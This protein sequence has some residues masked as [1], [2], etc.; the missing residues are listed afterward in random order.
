MTNN[1]TPENALT[2][3]KR[4]SRRR[5]IV[6]R[7]ALAAATILLA[8]ACASPEEKVA[9][10]T[11]SGEGFLEEG[12]WGKANVQFRNALKIDETHVPALEGMVVVAERKNNARSMFGLLQRIVR[13]DPTNV[14]AKTKI[15]KMYL[16]AGDSTEAL[17]IIDEALELAP[18][19]AEAIAAKSAILYKLEDVAQA[20]ELARKA[21]SIN[22]ALQEAVTVIAADLVKQG[23]I[24]GALKEID[25]ALAVDKSSTV[26]HLLRIEL[27]SKE[28]R[29]KDVDSAHRA[30]IEEYPDQAG[31]RQA[32]AQ[33][34]VNWGRLDEARDQL[35]TLTTLQPNRTSGYVDVVRVDYQLGGEE[36]ADATFQEFIKTRTD[37]VDLRFAYAA[38]LR[39]VGRVDESKPIYRALASLKDD[40]PTVLKAK[41]EIAALA[42]IDEDRETAEK[43]INEILELDNRNSEALI[44]K[45]TLR[46]LDGDTDGAIGDLR[47]VLADA[48]EIERAK[49]LIAAA[50]EKKGEIEAAEAQYAE[51]LSDTDSKASVAKAFSQFLLRHNKV[52]RAERVLTQAV[53]VNNQDQ[54]NLKLLAAIRLQKQDWRG[55]EE[56]AELLK[57]AESEDAAATRI[58]GVAYAGLEDFTGAIDVLGAEN[59]KTPLSSRPLSTLITAYMES[60]RAEEAETLLRANIDRGGDTYDA[61]VLLA[62]VLLAGNRNPEAKEALRDAIDATPGRFEAYEILYRV[63]RLEGRQSDASTLLDQ[64][65]SNAPENDGLRVLK[66]DL[67]LTNGQ[68]DEAL[69]LYE[70]VLTRRPNDI[71]VSNNYAA[72]L[73]DKTEDP[74]ALARAAQ[75]AKVLANSSNPSF[76]DTYGWATFRA[77]Q[78]AVGIAALEK[79]VAGA[80]D[81][82][83]AHFHLGVALHQTGSKDRARAHLTRVVDADGEGATPRAQRA[84]ELLDE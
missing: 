15:A 25:T 46:I 17:S 60:G 67:L 76:L 59:E 5:S 47:L 65:I 69:A 19:D 7:G 21:L 40:E 51:A 37:D 44:K 32:Y 81:L 62:R 39:Q 71:I 33:R 6:F 64:A 2:R 36:R 11:E 29:D 75:V 79:A 56:V 30:L 34:L 22:P 83:E 18:E 9:R 74:E 26:L 41:N 13:L 57:S 49:L 73:T 53:A 58:L 55:A 61:R 82:I 20:I 52:D 27:L 77:G 24:D 54:E 45:S 4:P 16:L 10:Y 84:K 28:G 35:V 50:Y 3:N 14:P 48:P 68:S 38:F 72:L 78:E 63:Y 43:L 1:H 70:D 80:P 31:Y 8:A 42:L 12:L 66:A 23:D